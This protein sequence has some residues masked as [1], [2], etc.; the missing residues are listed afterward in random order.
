MNIFLTVLCSTSFTSNFSYSM[1]SF[2][3][4]V[5]HISPCYFYMIYHDAIGWSDSIHLWITRVLLRLFQEGRAVRKF[6]YDLMFKEWVKK[7]KAD[8]GEVV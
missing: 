8:L 5:H 4:S 2:T 3:K 7:I 1:H 6:A